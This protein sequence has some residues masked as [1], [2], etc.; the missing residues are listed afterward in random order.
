MKIRK[1]IKIAVAGAAVAMPVAAFAMGTALTIHGQWTIG[2][3]GITATCPTGYTCVASPNTDETGFLQRQITDTNGKTFIQTV[4]AEGGVGDTFG[5]A[6]SPFFGDE[7]FVVMNGNGG[8]SGQS[9]QFETAAGVVFDNNALLNT[10]AEFM[11]MT[12]VGDLTD[13]VVNG[14]E[15][16]R[17]TT[18]ITDAGNEFTSAFGFDHGMTMVGGTAGKFSLITLDQNSND[19]AAGFTS[20]FKKSNLSFEGALAGNSNEFGRQDVISN[21]NVAGTNGITQTFRAS[22]R[23]GA[24]IGNGNATIL[25]GGK[26]GM[27]G[28]S[29]P[30]SAGDFVAEVQFNQDVA[31][32]QLFGFNSFSN[33]TAST[34][35]KNHTG[36]NFSAGAPFITVTD[37]TALD[38]FAP[39]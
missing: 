16:I 10:G 3:T 8:V 30:F 11:E 4:V 21:L 38:P 29:T 19:T 22:E 25:A 35:V 39:F 6:T 34:G 18:T 28:T 9:Q 15:M 24:G 17:L 33:L 2:A 13:G 32:G 37:D 14:A 12:M 26:N 23:S 20:S 27:V 5:A 36:T 1:A 31:G 7:T